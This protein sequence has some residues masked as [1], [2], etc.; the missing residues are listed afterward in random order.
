MLHHTIRRYMLALGILLVCTSCSSNKLSESDA[1]QLIEQSFA[2]EEPPTFKLPSCTCCNELP[3]EDVEKLNRL[4]TA[5]YIVYNTVEWQEKGLV[6]Q[7]YGGHCTSAIL[8][9]TKLFNNTDIVQDRIRLSSEDGF[10]IENGIVCLKFRAGTVTSTAEIV[11]MTEP[12]ANAEGKIVC[13]VTYKKYKKLSRN[14]VAELCDWQPTG[15]DYSDNPKTRQ[16]E[17]VKMQDGWRI[18][19]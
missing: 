4:R 13:V 12:A 15:S 5:G 16:A 8:E 2:A 6:T 10:P 11:S 17:F 7:H 1:K 3:K 9:E 18:L 19:H 14:A